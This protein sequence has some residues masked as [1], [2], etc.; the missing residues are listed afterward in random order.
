MIMKRPSFQFYPADWRKD[1]AL[2]TCSL[3]ARGLWIELMCVA[4]E[5]DEYGVLCVNGKPISDAQI[6]RIVGEVPN[7]VVKLIKELE[8]AGV[9]S[10]RQDGAIYSRRMV[11]D[12]HIRNVRA[13]AGRLG[14][15]PVLVDRLVDR[16]D[17][18]DLSNGS[19]L[20]KQTN[21]HRTTPSSS[22][23]SS[24]VNLSDANASS[25]DVRSKTTANRFADFWQAWPRSERKDAK[26][27]CE[28]KWRSQNLDL[29]A[30][31]I[32]AHVAVSKG[33]RKWVEGFEP[34]PLRYLSER[35]WEDGDVVLAEYQPEEVAVFE[36]YNATLHAAGWPE[37]SFDIYSVE[38]SENIKKF[39]NFRDKENW[40]QLYF[41][42]MRDKL[43]PR[44]GY[45]FDWVISQ[46]TF[47]RAVEGNFASM[48]EAA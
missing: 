31:K 36:Q 44:S 38:R 12:E 29:I 6:A 26:G 37:A 5:S 27:K 16:T 46:D 2:S 22:S 8:T 43:E 3:A 13:A 41:E 24:G 45:G 7:L 1:P 4:H 47:L 40:V 9:F 21:K 39:L 20:L 25:P 11:A 42:W 32:L 18:E 33:S 15:N 34:S 19:N 28:K 14:G 17:E 10:R 35:R 30:D 23:S 48:R